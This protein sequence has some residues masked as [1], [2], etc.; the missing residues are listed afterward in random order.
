MEGQ[1]E[2]TSSAGS[3]CP[4]AAKVK[5]YRFAMLSTWVS[6]KGKCDQV[7][8]TQKRLDSNKPCPVLM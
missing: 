4:L 7:N 5:H 3:V 1:E 6:N 8:A 2:P